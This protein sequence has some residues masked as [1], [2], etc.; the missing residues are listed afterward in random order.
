MSWD[1]TLLAAKIKMAAELQIVKYLGK[2]RKLTE[3]RLVSWQ[4]ES[5][6][7]TKRRFDEELNYEADIAQTVALASIVVSRNPRKKRECD[8]HRSSSWWVEGF[9][10]WDN[11]AFKKRLRVS[12]ETFDFILNEISDEI[13]KKPTRMKPNPTSPSTQLAVCLYR[14][15]HGCSYLTVG[16]LFGIAAPT[17]YCIFMDVC[18][19][20][21]NTLYD[22]MVYLPRTAE[23]WSNEL[24]GFIENWEFPCVG[25]WY[26]FHVY[27]STTLKNFYSYKKRYSVTN[28][29][30]IGYNKRFMF[31]AVGAPGS[32]HDS[33]LL[34][35]CDVYAKIEE[36]N[37]LPKSSLNLHPYMVKFH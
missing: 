18:K 11:A 27:V 6:I 9:R 4:T 32:T 5:G 13:A 23:E 15:A 22:R 33:R 3:E 7:R 2:K 10:T 31:A 30:F 1:G 26:G 35:N 25:A 24:K 12:R 28:M 34:Q 20:L 19:V 16:D 37:I 36:G 29:G 21:V 14:L 17:A 8:E